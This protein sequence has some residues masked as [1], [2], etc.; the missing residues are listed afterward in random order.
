[1][2]SIRRIYFPRLPNPHH[3]NLRVAA[4]CR[5]STKHDEQH[6]SL[7]MQIK[8]YEAYI[9]A[10][11]NWVFSGI[12]ADQG[13]GRNIMKRSQFQM[14]MN[15]CRNKEIDLILTKSISRFG[16][17]TVDVLN[18]F[19]ELKQLGIDVYFEVEKQYLSNPTSELLMTVLTAISQEESLQKSQK[20]RWG[21]KRSFENETSKYRNRICYGYSH[22]QYGKLIIDHA[23]AEIVKRIFYL[24]LNGF[25]L[26]QISRELVSRGIKSPRGNMIWGPETLN[27]KPLICPDKVRDPTKNAHTNI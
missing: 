5:V 12:Y 4:Y 13:T 21:I 24:R 11:P 15:K 22:D 8:Y 20:I 23:Q 10:H 14:M 18:C 19:R 9:R 16:R 3:K 27:Q 26:R 7:S 25:S 17:N 1:M 2:K 6:S